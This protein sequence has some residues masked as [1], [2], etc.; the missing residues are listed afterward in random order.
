M[1]YN[2]LKSYNG[3]SKEYGPSWNKR[4]FAIFAATQFRCF[5]CGKYAKGDLQLHHIIP[6][7]ISHDNSSKNLVPL[8]SRCHK[9]VHEKWLK[10]IGE[11]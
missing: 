2:S 3:P 11:W 7:K 1:V 10:S 8:C 5:N 6:I 9:K 4:R